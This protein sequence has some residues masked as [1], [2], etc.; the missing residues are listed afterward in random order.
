MIFFCLHGLL[1]KQGYIV[2][3]TLSNSHAIGRKLDRTS[4]Y[5]LQNSGGPQMALPSP[6][7]ALLEEAVAAQKRANIRSFGMFWYAQET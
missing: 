4:L 7:E 1:Q 2:P 3:K 6:E 5:F